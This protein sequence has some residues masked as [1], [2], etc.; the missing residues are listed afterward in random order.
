MLRVLVELATNEVVGDRGTL[1]LNDEET[2][3]LYS[4]VTHGKTTQDIRILNNSGISGHVFSTGKG[5]IAHDAYANEYFDRSV[6]KETGYVTKNVLCTPLRTIRGEVI[7][8]I[9]ILNKLKGRFTKKDLHIVEAMTT[10]VALTLKSAQLIEKMKLSREREIEFLDVVADVTSEINLKVLLQKVMGEATRMLMAER[11]TLFLNDKKTNQLW[12]EVG[13][14]LNMSQI[15]FPNHVGIAGVVFT[16][17]KTINIPHAYA[18]MRFNPKFDRETGFFTRSIL[19]VP[20]VNKTGEVIGVTQVLNKQG[21]PFTAEDES[22]LKAFTSQIAIGLENAKLF[23]DVQNMKNYNESMLESMSNGVITINDEGKIVTC[24]SASLNIMQ[25]SLSEVIGQKT[26]EFFS[27]ANEW[28]LAKIKQVEETRESEIFMDA[29]MAFSDE[30]SSVNLT[31]LPLTSA[32]QETLGTMIM[33]EDISSEKR[34]KSTMSRYMDPGIADQLLKGGD[35][36]LGGASTN[37]TI[38]FSDIR[39]FTTLTEELGAQGTV[40]LLNEYFT[41]MVECISKEEGM[42]DKFIGD[43]IMAAFGIPVAHDDDEDRAV[44]TGISMIREM[45]SWNKERISKGQK[46]IDMGLGINTDIVVSGNIGSPKRMDYTMIGDGVN[47]AARLES[48]CKQYSARIII[49]SNTLN[50]LRGTYRIRNIDDVV[51]KGK[52]E[53]VGIHEVLDYHTEETFPNLMEVVNYFNEGRKNYCIG[54]WDKAIDNFRH[55]LKFNPTD[56][57]SNTYIKRCEILKLETPSDWD[58]VWKMTAK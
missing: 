44:R 28:V 10:Q 13:E 41:L 20:V 47:L 48:A 1:F 7:G 39:G 26:E 46:P 53:P 29:E 18:D 2:G 55:A 5:V 45:F 50:K 24:N 34:M 23:N 12:S 52:T 56:N 51:V 11:S 32:E 54:N 30:L 14:G 57:L 3:E 37:A 27:G 16:T 31:I 58:G 21:G 36:F 4:R 40:A 19:C 33:M 35:D 38:L 43:A 25:V 15:N 8:V 22:R 49:S 6:D 42:L 17:G 9:Q